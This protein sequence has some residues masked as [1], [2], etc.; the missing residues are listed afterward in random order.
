MLIV[1]DTSHL[2]YLVLIGCVDVLP[3]LHHKV[4]IPS[5]V[6]R[7]LLSSG[8]PPQVREWAMHLPEWAELAEPE[9][10]FLDDPQLAGL[11]AGDRLMAVNGVPVTAQTQEEIPDV[12]RR[13]GLLSKGVAARLEF[14]RKGE[15]RT[16]E[17]TP[18]AKGRVEGEELA[19][20][21]W[22]FSVKA[23]NQFDNPDLYFQRHEGVF[24][25]GVKFP[26]NAASA[27]LTR[28]DILLKIDGKALNSPE[29]LPRMLSR[30]KPGD[31]IKVE[32][33]RDGKA[34]EIG[35]KLGKR[36]S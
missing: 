2:N 19:C 4:L 24:I 6:H 10:A 20:R 5:A 1:A 34:K 26:G 17:L 9:T 28:E 13:L 14:S 11:Q 8:A 22:D 31:E 27:G 15:V 30:K 12:N 35:V 21:R 33:S 32:Y 23:I 18:R 36:P 3:Q 16:V 25:Y 29:E 7:E